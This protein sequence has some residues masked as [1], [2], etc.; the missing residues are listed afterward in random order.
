[1]AQRLPIIMIADFS[2]PTISYRVAATRAKTY[3]ELIALTRRV[4]EKPIDDYNLHIHFDGTRCRGRALECEWDDNAYLGE[5]FL[6]QRGS[7]T[8]YVHFERKVIREQFG[9]D[10]LTM[11]GVEE[12]NTMELLERLENM[13][14]RIKRPVHVKKKELVVVKDREDQTHDILSTTEVAVGC[15]SSHPAPHLLASPHRTEILSS[16]I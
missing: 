16:R 5:E 9:K 14:Q 7:L 8:L 15:I 12:M 3:G 6:D 13:E 4:F 11:E 10:D 1:M 2:R